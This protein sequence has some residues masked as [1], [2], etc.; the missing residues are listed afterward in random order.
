MYSS[1]KQNES[2]VFY[3][4]AAYSLFIVYTYN[5]YIWRRERMKDTKI[6]PN[7]ITKLTGDHIL[8]M[9]VANLRNKHLRRKEVLL[10]VVLKD[11]NYISAKIK[12]VFSVLKKNE[13]HTC[14][15]NIRHVRCWLLHMIRDTTWYMVFDIWYS[16]R[17]VLLQKRKH[18]PVYCARTET[19]GIP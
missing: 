19:N 14:T 2:Y 1:G 5:T 10:F 3:G 17:V 18:S 6:D 16:L 15:K 11:N 8:Q 7:V 4:V 12:Q 13:T 9:R